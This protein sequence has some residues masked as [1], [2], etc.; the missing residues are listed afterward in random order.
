M[1]DQGAVYKCGQRIHL[2]VVQYPGVGN[3]GSCSTRFGRVVGG[4]HCQKPE[5][6]MNGKGSREEAGGTDIPTSLS[7][8]SPALRWLGTNRPEGKGVDGAPQ[9]HVPGHRAEWMRM[10]NRSGGANGRQAVQEGRQ[11]TF[12]R[13]L[14]LFAF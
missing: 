3:L 5:G 9:V 11:V 8:C 10:E 12:A 14:S 1:S 4:R 2:E 6:I 13:F 7:S